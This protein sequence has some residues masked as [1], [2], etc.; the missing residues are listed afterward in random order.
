MG[1]TM[2]R[3]SDSS[4]LQS[5]VGMRKVFGATGS[6][7]TFVGL[8]SVAQHSFV[9]ERSGPQ[10]AAAG[11]ATMAG[12]GFEAVVL[13]GNPRS[14]LERTEQQLSALVA[15]FG[16]VSEVEEQ[17]SSPLWVSVGV[18]DRASFAIKKNL[19]FRGHSEP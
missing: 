12:S 11:A 14:G 17:Q 3:I 9:E 8:M 5:M 19:A 10:H 2:R 1:S 13:T 7:A 15:A 4:T 6:L 16:A 18:E